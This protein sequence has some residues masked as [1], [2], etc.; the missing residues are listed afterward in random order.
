MTIPTLL[1]MA[2]IICWVAVPLIPHVSRTSST[3]KTIQKK[4]YSPLTSCRGV[5]NVSLFDQPSKRPI[6]CCLQFFN[7]ICTQ[8]SPSEFSYLQHILWQK[9]MLKWE[10]KSWEFE[11]EIKICAHLRFIRPCHWIFTGRLKN[12]DNQRRVIEQRQ[13]CGIVVVQFQ[14][15]VLSMIRTRGRQG[16]AIVATRRNKCRFI[17]HC[18][19]WFYCF[20]ELNVSIALV[21]FHYNWFTLFDFT[22]GLFVIPTQSDGISSLSHKSSTSTSLYRHQMTWS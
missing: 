7:N 11:W 4:M 3:D 21:C 5:I 14:H 20:L 15:C 9:T 1:A 12:G 22:P 19:D 10:K 2:S 18:F 13:T 8:L 17:F 6:H 16:V